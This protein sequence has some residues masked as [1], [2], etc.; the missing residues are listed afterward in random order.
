VE[1]ITP[2]LT[3]SYHETRKGGQGPVW[4][5][6]PLI[7]T[8]VWLVRRCYFRNTYFSCSNHRQVPSNISFLHKSLY[9]SCK[10]TLFGFY[11]WTPANSNIYRAIK[12]V[13]LLY[14]NGISGTRFLNL[15]K[16]VY[17]WLCSYVF[18]LCTCSVWLVSCFSVL[19]KNIKIHLGVQFGHTLR[20]E[21]TD[22]GCFKIIIVIII[23]VGRR[24]DE[25]CVIKNFIICTIY[26]KLLGL[27]D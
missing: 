20:E 21:N 3:I 22:C 19:S 9:T 24:R 14:K 25:N 15:R 7:I 2:H 18:H 26:M 27:G 5:V 23:I 8:I 16:I 17:V 12:L 13:T 10:Y 11:C 6:T 4:A 1:L